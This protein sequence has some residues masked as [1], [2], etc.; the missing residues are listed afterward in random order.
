[1]ARQTKFQ[2]SSIGVSIQEIYILHE[3]TLE[4]L[5]N[6]FTG[7]VN[8]KLAT[9]EFMEKHE[10]GK[11]SVKEWVYREIDLIF[12]FLVIALMEA[13]FRVDFILRT[14]K[15]DKEEVSLKM[16]KIRE[17]YSKSPLYQI[18]INQIINVWINEFDDR[19]LRGSLNNLIK[20][21]DN[22][23][24]WFAHGRYWRENRALETYNFEVI[25][26]FALQTESIIGKKLKH[27][28]KNYP[29]QLQTFLTP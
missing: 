6:S 26:A 28:D 21:I 10:N 13:R 12:C 24:N 5:T 23:R 3:I 2:F 27:F 22:F 18:P 7:S 25:Y 9:P 4:A 29:Q 15:K 14:D 20:A 1:M 19:R 8:P 16:R 17:E 11:T